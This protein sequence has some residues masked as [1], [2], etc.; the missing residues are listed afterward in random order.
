MTDPLSSPLAALSNLL[1]D[2][3]LNLNLTHKT[4]VQ[5]CMFNVTYR[6]PETLY[7]PMLFELLKKIRVSHAMF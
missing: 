1:L 7:K 4:T 3:N 6:Q 5:D 2:L